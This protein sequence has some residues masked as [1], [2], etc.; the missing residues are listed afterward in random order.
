MAS[1]AGKRKTQDFELAARAAREL[2]NIDSH[3]SQANDLAAANP[4][5][6]RA[7]R[8]LWWAEAAKHTSCRA[9][10]EL[11]GDGAKVAALPKGEVTS[12]IWP[13]RGATTTSAGSSRSD[14]RTSSVSG[15]RPSR[16]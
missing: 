8:A 6:L 12:D 4:E 14:P 10:I 3:F 16:G 9:E 1:S 13:P 5:K 2:Y 15:T 7:L 11:P